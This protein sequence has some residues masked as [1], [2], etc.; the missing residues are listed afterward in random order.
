MRSSVLV[1]ILAAVVPALSQELSAAEIPPAC[2]AICEPIVTL[3]GICDIRTGQSSQSDKKLRLRM[4][5]EPNETLQEEIEATC[6][7]TN[8]SFEVANIMALCASC[9][10][11]NGQ[12]TA[13]VDKMMRECFFAPKTYTPADT[14]AAAGIQVQATKPTTKVPGS[15]GNRNDAA[16]FIAA[17]VAGTIALLSL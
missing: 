9:I 4:P 10:T 17:V 2:T 3:A 5:K 8:N 14:A 11:Q 12:T 6:V 7:C 15:Y 1:V 16:S 13:G